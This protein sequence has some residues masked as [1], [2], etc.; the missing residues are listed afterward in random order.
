MGSRWVFFR[1][2]VLPAGC[3][4]GGHGSQE[5]FHPVGCLL[6]GAAL[7]QRLAVISKLQRRKVEASCLNAHTAG[8]QQPQQGLRQAQVQ[9]R[10]KRAALPHA[11]QE[12]GWAGEAAVEDGRCLRL[13][14]QQLHPVHKAVAKAQ[15]PQHC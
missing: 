9:Q 11:G 13:H 14:Q 10:G 4:K 8:L 6:R 1:V 3:C 7:E 2:E 5:G 12:Q 15:L